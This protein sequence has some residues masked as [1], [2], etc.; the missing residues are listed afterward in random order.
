MPRILRLLVMFCFI[1]H[2]WAVPEQLRWGVERHMRSVRH[3]KLQRVIRQVQASLKAPL[4]ILSDCFGIR[5]C[6]C[7]WARARARARVRDVPT[8]CPNICTIFHK[9]C[10]VNLL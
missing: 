3:W 1:V 9:N 7:V 5:V 6:V 2:G 8:R 4:L 10:R